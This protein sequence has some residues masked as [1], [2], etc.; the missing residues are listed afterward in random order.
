MFFKAHFLDLMQKNNEN[1][2]LKSRLN[3]LKNNLRNL[4]RYSFYF[5]YK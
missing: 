5:F 2:I 4:K 1:K 3:F